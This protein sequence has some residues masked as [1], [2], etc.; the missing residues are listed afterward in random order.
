MHTQDT[1]FRLHMTGAPEAVGIAAVRDAFAGLLAKWPDIRFDT[2]RPSFWDGGFVAR[3][4]T[5]LDVVVAAHQLGV[6]G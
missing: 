3:N 2:E 6:L 5:C 1:V 4:E